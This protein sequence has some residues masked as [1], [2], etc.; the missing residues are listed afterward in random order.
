VSSKGDSEII[1]ISTKIDGKV[2]DPLY[3]IFKDNRLK[4]TNKLP[5]LEKSLTQLSNSFV[6]C[7]ED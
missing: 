5:D 2:T 7:M 3:I 4:K 1:D 6:S